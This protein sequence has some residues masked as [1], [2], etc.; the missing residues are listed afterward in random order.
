MHTDDEVREFFA[1]VVLPTRDVWVA[2]A[3]GALVGVLVLEGDWVDHLYIVPEWTGHGLGA[4]FL[5]LAKQE[6]PAGLQLWA[7]Q[8]NERAL[9]FYERHG[10]VAME[11][12]DGDNEEGEPDVRY[13]WNVA[14]G[15]GD[16][17]G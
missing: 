6:R 4:R 5:D 7:F 12:T 9:R 15:S 17:A 16:R 8:S 13:V 1:S 14:G 11:T 3:D 2:E 10:F